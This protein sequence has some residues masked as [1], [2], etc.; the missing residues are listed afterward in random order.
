MKSNIAN[1]NRQAS[2]GKACHPSALEL[3]V[4]WIPQVPGTPFFYPVPDLATAKLLVDAL[5]RYDL[6]QFDN[7]IKPDYT[8]DG[9]ASWRH[10]QLTDGEWWDFDPEDEIEYAEV[11][12]ACDDQRGKD[13]L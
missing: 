5:A 9:G 11:E 10:A 13:A 3:R 2:E 7:N 6:F 1:D 12:A 4:W 8:N